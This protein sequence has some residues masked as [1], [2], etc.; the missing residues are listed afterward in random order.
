MIQG[1]AY[2]LLAKGETRRASDLKVGDSVVSVRGDFIV[3]DS[4]CL[5]SITEI[6]SSDV[7]MMQVND[8]TIGIDSLFV[9]EEGHVESAALGSKLATIHGSDDDYSFDRVHS[10]EAIEGKQKALQI[11]TKLSSY[12]AGPTPSGPFFLF[13]AEALKK[14]VKTAAKKK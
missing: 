7:E 13:H 8:M 1:E 4:M 14:P 5:A 6:E 10:I 2:V 12:F 9:C 11:V 3:G